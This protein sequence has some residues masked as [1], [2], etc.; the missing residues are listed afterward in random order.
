[1]S[2]LTMIGMSFKLKFIFHLDHFWREK[3]LPEVKILTR[4]FFLSG[5]FGRRGN[6]FLGSEAASVEILAIRR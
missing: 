3:E 4:F 2:V 6:A 1:M 5:R